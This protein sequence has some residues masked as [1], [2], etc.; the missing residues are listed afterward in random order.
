MTSLEL[1]EKSLNFL[2]SL[3][4]YFRLLF[5]FIFEGK[6]ILGWNDGSE[7]DIAIYHADAAGIQTALST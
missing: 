1:A 6:N 5:I 2:F 3:Q 7:E 4:Y